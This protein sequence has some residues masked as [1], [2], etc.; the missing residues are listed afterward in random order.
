MGTPTTQCVLL[1]MDSAVS[2]QASDKVTAAIASCGGQ[3]L[4]NIDRFQLAGFAHNADGAVQAAS[5]AQKLQLALPSG[6]VIVLHAG[7]ADNDALQ[8]LLALRKHIGAGGVGVTDAVVALGEGRLPIPLEPVESSGGMTGF[9]AMV[10]TRFIDMTARP[11]EAA[12]EKTNT[13]LI[14]AQNGAS[15]LKAPRPGA[16]A[17]SSANSGPGLTESLLERLP[18]AAAMKLVVPV[19]VFVA[20]FNMVQIRDAFLKGRDSIL[21][22]TNIG[23]KISAETAKLDQKLTASTQSV[24]KPIDVARQAAAQAGQVSPE[25]LALAPEIKA[26]DVNAKPPPRPTP[27]GAQSPLPTT[28]AGL[29]A[30]S[31]ASPAASPASPTPAAPA[32]PPESMAADPLSDLETAILSKCASDAELCHSSGQAAL[33]DGR[34]GA[35]ARFFAQACEANLDKSCTQIATM[36]QLGQGV[37]RSEAKARGYFEKSCLKGTAPAC[38]E[39]GVSLLRDAATSDAIKKARSALERGCELGHG[40]ACLMLGLESAVPAGRAPASANLSKGC[41]LMGISA[42][43]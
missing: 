42:C 41:Q 10:R 25:L 43:P 2:T 32:K 22:N 18:I 13:K 36:Y 14:Y 1:A 11:T 17:S 27:P 40:P 6:A 19:L 3:L 20:Y 5:C 29:Q 30:L 15:S 33:K 24:L 7:L 28:P 21:Q 37:D 8:R 12:R 4:G 9:Y 34:T 35:A 16:A 38:T 26:E 23:R 31:A 39:L